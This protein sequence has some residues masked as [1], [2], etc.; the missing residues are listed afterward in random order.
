MT[1]TLSPNINVPNL[2]AANANALVLAI[3]ISEFS[4]C[5]GGEPDSVYVVPAL[6]GALSSDIMERRV[7]GFWNLRREDARDPARLF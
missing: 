5:L 6:V 3:R 7:C 2:P 1:T 4:W